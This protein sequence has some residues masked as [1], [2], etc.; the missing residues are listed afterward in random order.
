MGK[1][2]LSANMCSRRNG[3]Q[4]ERVTHESRWFPR[5]EEKVSSIANTGSLRMLMALTVLNTSF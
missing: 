2:S 5:D 1:A 4:L 3:C